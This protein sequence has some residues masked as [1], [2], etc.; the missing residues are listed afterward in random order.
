M[1]FAH[2]GHGANPALFTVHKIIAPVCDAGERFATLP[3]PPESKPRRSPDE[4]DRRIDRRV[5]RPGAP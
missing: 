3:T 1:P 4:A 5:G 2:R